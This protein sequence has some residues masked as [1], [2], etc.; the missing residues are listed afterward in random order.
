MVAYKVVFVMNTI[1]SIKL[2]ERDYEL[3]GDRYYY[4]FKGRLI[5]ALIDAGSIPEAE[6]KAYEIIRAVAF[7]GYQATE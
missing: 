6:D 7:T 2:V 3:A 1:A 4:E 5:Y